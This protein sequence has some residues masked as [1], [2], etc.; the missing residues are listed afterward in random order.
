MF[1]KASKAKAKLRMALTGPS[2]SG[3]TYTALNLAQ[4]LGSKVGL[5]DTEHGSASKY[6]DR[7]SF[8][9]AELNNFHPNKYIEAINTASSMG[10][11][12]IVVDSLS[13]AWFWELDASATS[14]S[15]NSFTAWAKIRPLERALITALLASPAH[16]IVTMRSKTEWVIEQTTNKRGDSVSMPRRVGTAPVQAGGIEYEFDLAGELD[17]VHTLTISKSRCPELAD[18]Q[19]HCPGK[20]LADKLLAWLDDGTPVGSVVFHTADS[21]SA[22]DSGS[23]FSPTVDRTLIM[24]DIGEELQRLGWTTQDGK[25]YLKDKYEKTSRQQLSEAELA[26]FLTDLRQHP[27]PSP[28]PAEAAPDILF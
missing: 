20:E 17:L 9:V 26:E 10:Y 16:V 27:S 21:P 7:F 25:R 5:I 3:K 14:S 4:H 19:Q 8:D 28:K 24:A 12:V 22:S 2:G 11:E 23:G 15:G 13:H 1:K 18:T 6:A